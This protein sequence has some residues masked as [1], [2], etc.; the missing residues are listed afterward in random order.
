M[1]FPYFKVL[2]FPKHQKRERFLPWIK[3]G[4]FSQENKN[5]ILYPIGLIDSGSEVTIV[6]CEFAEELGIKIKKGKKN[7]ISGVGGGIIEVWFHQVGL[8]VHDESD[9]RP[10]IY[11]DLVGFTYERF[12][13][14]MPQQ[15]AILGT[16]G[17]FRNLK[18][19][20]DYPKSIM[21]EPK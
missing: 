14:T 3:F 20:F 10:I 17:F 8:L 9:G 16:I 18:V 11:Q 7:K 6:D 5:K 12:P 2:D 15:T 13:L 1:E 4:I 19:A 21:I